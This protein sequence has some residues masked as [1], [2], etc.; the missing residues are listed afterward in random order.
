MGAIFAA[1]REKKADESITNA[2]NAANATKHSFAVK[3]AIERAFAAYFGENTDVT[4]E[5]NAEL[6]GLFCL[7]GEIPQN[8]YDDAII[9]LLSQYAGDYQSKVL[10]RAQLNLRV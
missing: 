9:H 6:Y 7:P 5:F 2:I 10:A 8:L 1:S 3:F 4:N